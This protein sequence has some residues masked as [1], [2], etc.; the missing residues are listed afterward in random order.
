[1]EF[2]DANCFIGLPT[3]AVHR[4]VATAADLL[5]AMDAAGVGQ[6]LVWHVAQRDYDATSGNRLLAEAIAP[7]RDRLFGCWSL[8]PPQTGEL[9]GRETRC[10]RDPQAREQRVAR[11]TSTSDFFA[12][13]AKAGMRAVRAWP[14]NHRFLLREEVFG[15]F[16]EELTARRVP[17][18]LSLAGGVDWENVYDLLR[19]FPE[20]T[21][22]LCDVGVW[23]M[24]R[25]FRP[26]IE[27]YPNCC[28]ETSLYYQD[29]GIRDFVARYGPSRLLYGSGLPLRDHSMM[30]AVARAEISPADRQ[31][32]AGGNLRRLLEQVKLP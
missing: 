20:L 14:K 19:D 17:L 3:L 9:V 32:I 1:M 16:F 10:S 6:A 24:D 7:H 30:L 25:H 31:A 26:L 4:P 8:L 5:A 23:G 15:E 13:M 12:V 18:L 29:G 22:V 27:R 2:F 28:L 11:P 21:C